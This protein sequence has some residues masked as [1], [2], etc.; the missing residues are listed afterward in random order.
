MVLRSGDIVPNQAAA[1]RLSN[2]WGRTW[3]IFVH[4]D[5]EQFDV[6]EQQLRANGA[7]IIKGSIEATHSN[8]MTFKNIYVQDRTDIGLYSDKIKRLS[9]VMVT[10]DSLCFILNE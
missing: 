4:V 9:L 7:N 6:L 3:D 8:G 2:G 1:K 10:K 5:Y